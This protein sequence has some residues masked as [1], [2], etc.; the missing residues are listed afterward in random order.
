MADRA[1]TLVVEIAKAY[2][3]ALRTHVPGWSRG[4]LRFNASDDHYGSTA[5]YVTPSGVSL[6]DP[7]RFDVLFDQINEMGFELRKVLNHQHAKKF[8]VFLLT[9]DSNF[10]FRID[11]EWKDSDKWKITKTGGGSGIPE[12]VS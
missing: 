12:G 2:I 4:F 5:S 3:T 8:C 1:S 11:Y 9:V 10:D 7:F 6:L